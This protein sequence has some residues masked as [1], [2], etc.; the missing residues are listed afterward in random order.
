MQ[1]AL[2]AN[3]IAMLT[4]AIPEEH[5]ALLLGITVEQLRGIGLLCV[6]GKYT[7]ADVTRLLATWRQLQ[8]PAHIIH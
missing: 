7:P 2:A 3:P 1:E 4:C 5:T 8:V 6:D